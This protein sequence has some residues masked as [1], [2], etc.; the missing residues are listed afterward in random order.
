MQVF[1]VC[2]CGSSLISWIK[3]NL[4]C[5]QVN[6]RALFASVRK[7]GSQGP[8]VSRKN[9]PQ[10]S[11]TIGHGMVRFRSIN[12]IVIDLYEITGEKKAGSYDVR[13]CFTYQ[14][15]I[16]VCAVDTSLV[17]DWWWHMEVGH[18]VLF[19]WKL[20]SSKISIL[21]SKSKYDLII[22]LSTQ[23]ELEITS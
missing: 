18:Y 19:S 13:K 5:H 4:C 9:A 7:Y 10:V 8:S 12:L 14:L 20:S 3:K 16:F 21:I 15:H 1:T 6:N 11:S 17:M 23:D 22:K 2:S